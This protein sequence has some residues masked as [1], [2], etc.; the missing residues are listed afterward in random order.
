PT[1]RTHYLV[2]PGPDAPSARTNGAAAALA[3]V[4]P[5]L[6]DPRLRPAIE[7]AQEMAQRDPCADAVQ[8]ERRLDGAVASAD[9]DHALL[10]IGV[11]LGEEVRY[12]RQVLSR[13]ADGVG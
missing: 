8:I 3:A 2:A 9:H 11:R 5:V 13:H 10:P 4:G 7:F 6:P 12:V 1:G